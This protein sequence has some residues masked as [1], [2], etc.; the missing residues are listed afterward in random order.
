M[1]TTPTEIPVVPALRRAAIINMLSKQ[2]RIDGRSF[3][4]TRSVEIATGVI[5]NASGSAHVK[6]GLTQVICGVKLELGTPFHD[7]PAMGN[8]VVNAEF[9]PLASPTFE[10]GPP[11]ERAIELARVVDRSLRDVKAIDLSKLAPVP[12][13]RVWNVFVDIYV[14]DHDGNLIDASSIAALAALLTARVPRASADPDKGEVVID[15]NLSEPLPITRK[16]I[17]ATVARIGDHFVA[18]PS[19]EEELVADAFI[20]FAFSED[21]LVTGIQKSGL[22]GFRPDQLR[23]AFEIANKAYKSYLA[24]VEAALARGSG[25]AGGSG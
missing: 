25:Q 8:L 17:T 4:S 5:Q 10:P 7:T 22:G 13:K 16:V 19:L 11:D 6:L 24:S 23:R 15:R 18:D 20:T 3:E 1:S 14:I 21:G 2:A 9:V 12:G